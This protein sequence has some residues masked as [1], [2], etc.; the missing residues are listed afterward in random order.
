[1]TVATLA[2][3]AEFH[4]S[5]STASHGCQITSSA[6]MPTSEQKKLKPRPSTGGTHI[7]WR[8]EPDLGMVA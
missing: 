7:A 8:V 1:M 2:M 3:C 5:G 4:A 6:E